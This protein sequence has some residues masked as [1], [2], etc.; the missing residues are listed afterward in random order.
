M[1]SLGFSGDDTNPCL[2]PGTNTD[3]DYSWEGHPDCEYAKYTVEITSPDEG[4]VF[5]KDS[6]STGSATAQRVAESGTT[7]E[8][9]NTITWSDGNSGGTSKDFTTIVGSKTLTA[10]ANGVSHSVT[11]TIVEITIKPPADT[12]DGSAS[13]QFK[14]EVNPS[15]TTIDSYEWSYST[16][17]GA[18]RVPTSDI[19]DSKTSSTPKV[20]KAQWFATT[21]SAYRKESKGD[22]PS[23]KYTIGC[24]VTIN[25]ESIDAPEVD[26]G[27]YVYK[28]SP[29]TPRR[30][31]KRPSGSGGNPI[32]DFQVSGDTVTV[33]NHFMTE[34][35]PTVGSIN[36]NGMLS[37]NTFYGKIITSHEGKHVTQWTSG[38]YYKDLFDVAAIY[39]LYS[40]DT[41]TST[42]YGDRATWMNQL[43]AKVA[44]TFDDYEA[45]CEDFADK[46]W[47]RR[48]KEAHQISNPVGPAYLKVSFSEEYKN[49]SD[50]IP[51][52]PVPVRIP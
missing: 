42:S 17:A 23:C 18:A 41:F 6:G 50:P 31:M 11:V 28:N 21:G 9:N 4:D 2:D 30:K 29:V 52:L 7:D 34:D 45:V 15:T 26:W 24:K 46:T 36:K 5:K 8:P 40:G 10:S 1:S 20:T 48:E 38:N 3:P 14:I 49:A 22:D 19:F 39:A 44:Q 32:L 47:H 43:T 37:S 51:A 35:V 27:V 33:V 13:G 25:G 16:P 12:Q